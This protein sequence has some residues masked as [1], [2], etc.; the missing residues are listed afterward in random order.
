MIIAKIK[1]GDL[2][3]QVK[4]INEAV[5]VIKNIYLESEVV[6]G[7][8]LAYLKIESSIETASQLL[9]TKVTSLQPFN[10]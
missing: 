7:E 4:D 1:N 5:E 2:N 9:M 3:Y 10:L 8:L 6:I